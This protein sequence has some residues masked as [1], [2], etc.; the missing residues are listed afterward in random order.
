MW[1]VIAIKV[2]VSASFKKHLYFANYKLDFS[3][4]H[5]YVGQTYYTCIIVHHNCHS[6]SYIILIA[7]SVAVLKIMSEMKYIRLGMHVFKNLLP[8]EDS[9][10]NLIICPWQ[11]F[12][13]NTHGQNPPIFQDPLCHAKDFEI[14]F[15][16]MH[17]NDEH[18]MS[19]ADML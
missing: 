19:K 15:S 14:Q 9:D 4:L 7:I 18:Y 13:L 17:Y 5:G 8:V 2:C 10:Q 3:K 16:K 6:I 11:T 1:S 12:P